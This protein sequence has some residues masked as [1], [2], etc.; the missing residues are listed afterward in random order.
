MLL[1][2]A[3]INLLNASHSALAASEGGTYYVCSNADTSE[4]QITLTADL[5]DKKT[6]RVAVLK[7][8]GIPKEYFEVRNKKPAFVFAVGQAKNQTLLV[9][10]DQRAPALI[11]LETDPDKSEA[12]VA[13]KDDSNGSTITITKFNSILSVPSEGINQES[14]SCL[15]TKWSNAPEAPPAPR[16]KQSALISI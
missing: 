7:I 8:D 6:D 2:V 13:H 15:E 3:L 5:S 9:K 12:Q 16:S 10:K 11:S 4:R 14:V 1:L